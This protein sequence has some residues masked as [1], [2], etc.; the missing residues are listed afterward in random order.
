M[1]PLPAAKRFAKELTTE[2]KTVNSV[3][4]AR[5]VGSIR[6]W[7]EEVS[8][9]NV[10]VCIEP[11]A[12]ATLQNWV[13]HRGVDYTKAGPHSSS[14]IIPFDEESVR[15][16]FFLCSE[17][18]WGSSLCYSTGSVRH[19]AELKT[20]LST[21]GLM[22]NEWG[23][24]R[25]G[26]RVCGPDER[27]IYEVASLPFHPPE[28]REYGLVDPIPSLVKVRNVTV[29]IAKPTR[30]TGGVE[31]DHQIRQA[32]KA[33]N[34]TIV[35]ADDISLLGSNWRNYS[36]HMQYLRRKHAGQIRVLIAVRASVDRYGYTNVPDDPTIDLIIASITN[37]P[38]VRPVDRLVTA[39]KLDHRIRLVSNPTNRVVGKGVP[40][41]PWGRLL[42]HAARHRVAL[43]INTDTTRLDLPAPLIR[44]ANLVGCKF[45]ITGNNL[46]YGVKMARKGLVTIDRLAT[47]NDLIAGGIHAY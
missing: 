33:G 5:V 46:R 45:V 7:V 4:N 34:E 43:E 42:K 8:N 16:K 28:I 15:A 18:T 36:N 29:T 22:M 6:R 23:V 26:N 31:S 14:V 19:N 9:V 38:K 1:I 39:L 13:S 37:K 25:S 47:Y 40:D 21:M 20:R 17:L 11:T 10:L 24:W 32:I 30:W 35:F 2:L 41:R 44:Y 27:E 3:L 12:S